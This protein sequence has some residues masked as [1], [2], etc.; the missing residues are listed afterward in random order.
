MFKP[1]EEFKKD[2]EEKNITHIRAELVTIA[3]EDRGFYTTQFDDALAYVETA[4]IEG[5]F[6]P[7]NGETFKPKEEWNRN[8]WTYLVSS[9]MDNFCK[10]RINHL[11]EVGRYVYPDHHK[12]EDNHSSTQ[13]TEAPQK[14][15]VKGK[16]QSPIIV[17]G[18]AAA[19][20]LIGYTIIG[21]KTAIGAAIIAGGIMMTR[22]GN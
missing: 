5:L 10:E 21:T 22:K 18:V 12:N 17:L 3:H 15:R 20:A 9:L 4:H 13:K 16:K 11:K 1:S 2:I 14:E 8:Y 7:F 19:A 6:V